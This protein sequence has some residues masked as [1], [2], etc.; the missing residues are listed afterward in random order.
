MCTQE[1]SIPQA[2]AWAAPAS[3]VV[4]HRSQCSASFPCPL[5]LLSLCW[6]AEGKAGWKKGVSAFNRRC[7]KLGVGVVSGWEWHRRKFSRLE[8]SWTWCDILAKN[9]SKRRWKEGRA[10]VS[11]HSTWPATRADKEGAARQARWNC[12]DAIPLLL[13]HL[14][15]YHKSCAPQICS[16][17]LSD[18]LFLSLNTVIHHKSRFSNVWTHKCINKPG[19]RRKGRQAAHHPWL[20]QA[21]GVSPLTHLFPLLCSSI[22]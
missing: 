6:G 14:F 19:I 4:C 11:G 18:I 5:P 21:A 15:L 7:D 10:I 1:Q 9:F 13:G 12:W 3:C 8:K 22:W 16:P 2:V 17:W 20:Y